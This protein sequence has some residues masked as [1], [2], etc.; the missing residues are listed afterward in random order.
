MC[1]VYIKQ[2]CSSDGK[3]IIEESRTQQRGVPKNILSIISD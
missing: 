1:V 3:N 2:H